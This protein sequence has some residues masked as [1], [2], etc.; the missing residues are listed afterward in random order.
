M[1]LIF[2]RWLLQG[3]LIDGVRQVRH[4]LLNLMDFTSERARMSVITRAP[5]GTIRLFCKG[6]DTKVP[7]H[8]DPALC[9]SPQLH[10][11]SRLPC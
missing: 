10:G 6:A 11:I 8:A 9:R 4:E 5:D 2:Y 1:C 3:L 7:G